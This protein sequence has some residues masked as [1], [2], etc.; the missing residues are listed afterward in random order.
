MKPS[1]L[2]R[3]IRKLVAEQRK[4][5]KIT[6]DHRQ[7]VQDRQKRLQGLAQE[8]QQCRTSLTVQDPTPKNLVAL[9]S[10]TE[11]FK[12]ELLEL[13]ELINEYLRRS[14]TRI[15]KAEDAV[16]RLERL[17]PADQPVAPSRTPRLISNPFLL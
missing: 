10:Q 17:V 1:Q 12:E 6:R 13:A 5:Q 7:I 16:A 8:F 9:W 14:Q 2:K 15:Q 4:V 11:S 3:K